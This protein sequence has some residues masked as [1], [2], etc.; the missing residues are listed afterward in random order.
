MNAP[1]YVSGPSQLPLL[2]E[3]IGENLRRVV[4]RFPDREALVS[5]HQGYRA[6]YRQFWEE[7]GR[8]ARALLVRGVK[9]GDRVGV[10]APNRHEWVVLQYATAR[11][12]AILVNINPAYR[13]HELEYALKHSGVS[14]LVLAKAFRGAD[15]VS[16]VR[17]VRI[18]CPELRQ[19]IVIEDEWADLREDA[20]RLSEEELARVE[21]DLQFDDAI[22]IQYTSGTTGFPKGATL[23]HHNILNN[24]FFIGEFLRYT[25][26]DRV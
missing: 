7:T 1:S 14:T 13:L 10:W 12:G 4:E 23:S 18:R 11:M 22:N 16:M 8:I 6:T 19:T 9:K 2:G 17:D 3:T 24:G 5:V 21:K 26:Q 20:R 25:E 15:Y